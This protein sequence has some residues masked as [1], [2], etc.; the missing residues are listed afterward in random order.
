MAP[1]DRGVQRGKENPFLGSGSL[2]A[3]HL[4]IQVLDVILNVLG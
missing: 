1:L 2:G 3:M 4:T